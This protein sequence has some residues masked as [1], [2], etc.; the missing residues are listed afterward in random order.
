MTARQPASARCQRL[1]D[2][3]KETHLKSPSD[4]GLSSYLFMEYITRGIFMKQRTIHW[5]TKAQ[6]AEIIAA[7]EADGYHN[8]GKLNQEYDF[9][10]IIADDEKRVFFGTNTT[11]MAALASSRMKG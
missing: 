10:V 2:G 9:P 5:S 4:D 3:Q 1:I 8:V 6:L 7:L 11:C